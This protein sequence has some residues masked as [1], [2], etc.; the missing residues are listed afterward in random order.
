VRYSCLILIKFYFLNTLFIKVSNFK[1]HK[2]RPVGA[3]LINA[4]RQADITKLKGPLRFYARAPNKPRSHRKR[5]LK[6]ESFCQFW[7]KSSLSRPKGLHQKT[8]T[9]GVASVLNQRLWQQRSDRT[10]KVHEERT[11]KK[12][13]RRRR[14]N[15]RS[16]QYGVLHQATPRLGPYPGD[17]T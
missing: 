7:N 13:K 1:F 14:R 16:E 17:C 5:N 11:L 9:C 2:N 15:V 3:A 6:P 10:C 12:K 8:F 4:D